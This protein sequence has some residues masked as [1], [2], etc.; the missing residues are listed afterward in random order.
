M[1]SGACLSSAGFELKASVHA[2]LDQDRNMSS[3][4]TGASACNG[5]HDSLHCLH[6]AAPWRTTG[7]NEL[8]FLDALTAVG[9]SEAIKQ[10]LS[11]PTR[12]SR[13]TIDNNYKCN[14]CKVGLGSWGRGSAFLL[15]GSG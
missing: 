9:V 13:R 7:R 15:A 8:G 6:P 1:T 4:H 10:V 14:L 2:L 11:L 12:T 5:L 3:S